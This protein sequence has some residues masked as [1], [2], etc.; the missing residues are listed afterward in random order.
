MRL[1]LWK[2][3]ELEY[4]NSEIHA[5]TTVA[6]TDKNLEKRGDH[7]RMVFHCQGM[8]NFKL[9]LTRNVWGKLFSIFLNFSRADEQVF[10]RWSHCA[11]S[12]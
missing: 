11:C 5:F 2:E 12:L 10:I 4:T 7:R 9:F 6:V 3:I 8:E 1:E